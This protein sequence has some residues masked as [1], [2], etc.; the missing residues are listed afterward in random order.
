VHSVAAIEQREEGNVLVVSFKDFKILD[1]Q[2]IAEIG[3][4]LTTLVGQ[5]P[6]GRML[7]NFEGVTFMSSAM[8]GKIIQLNKNCK[9]KSVD[10]RLCSISANVMEVFK[11]M[12]LNKVLNIQKDEP[13]AIKS[14]DKKGLFG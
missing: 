9:D 7:V 5:T 12:R 6:A 10:L 2:R 14:F 4:E 13:T 11:L 1:E 3:Y 8:I